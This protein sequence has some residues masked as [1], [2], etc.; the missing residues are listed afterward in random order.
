MLTK[1]KRNQRGEG[2]RLKEELI[3]AAMRLLDRS[4]TSPISLRMVAKEAGVAAP[5]TY[6][7]F[8]NA[9]ALMSEIVRECWRQM[10]AAMASSLPSED[11]DPIERLQQQMVA[12]VE[13]AMERPSRYQL[14]FAM[15]PIEPEDED[16]MDGYLRP[17]YRQ[18]VDTL[19]KHVA[20]GGHLPA[21]D[22]MSAALL[23]ISLTHGRIALAHLAPNRRGNSTR[24]VSKFVIDQ[25]ERAFQAREPSSKCVGS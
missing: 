8:E 24:S 13:Y 7:H 16:A 9:Q 22:L 6:S 21:K 4:P 15:Q 10:G 19:E 12:F 2:A 1:R 17:A 18:V 23:V 25:I 5:S 3:E 11:Q 20:A 14:L